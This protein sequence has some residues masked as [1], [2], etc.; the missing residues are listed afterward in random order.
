MAKQTYES[1]V[2]RLEE[3]VEILEKGSLPLEESLILFEEGRIL[4]DFCNSV[5]DSAEQKLK[6]L[7][8]NS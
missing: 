4:A 6:T 8:D 3:I 1:A 7:D 5:L 2:K